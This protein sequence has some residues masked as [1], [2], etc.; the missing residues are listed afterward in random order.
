MLGKDNMFTL[1]LIGIVTN[2]QLSYSATTLRVLFIGSSYSGPAHSVPQWARGE[3]LIPGALLAAQ[4]INSRDDILQELEIEVVPIV[5]PNCSIVEGIVKTMEEILEQ[6]NKMLSVIGL[7]CNK[8]A[9]VIAALVSREPVSLIQLSGATAL[10]GGLHYPHHYSTLAGVEYHARAILDLMQALNWT[11]IGLLN[12]VSEFDNYYTTLT[13]AFVSEVGMNTSV[14]I[15]FHSEVG[16]YGEHDTTVEYA[17]RKVQLSKIHIVVAF[18][19]PYK[20]FDLIC[21]AYLQGLTWPNYA[22]ILSDVPLQ[23]LHKTNTSDCNTETLLRAMEYVIVIQQVVQPADPHGNLVSGRSYTS[24]M[25][26][27]TNHTNTFNPFANIVYDSVWGLGLASNNSLRELQNQSMHTLTALDSNT[28]NTIGAKLLTTHFTGASGTFQFSSSNNR[29]LDRTIHISQIHNQSLVTIGTLHTNSSNTIFNLSNLGNNPPTSQIAR[30]YITVHIAATVT[31]T[32]AACASLLLVIGVFLLFIFY[33]NQAEVKAASKYLSISM[34]LGCCLLLVGA[35]LHSITSHLIITRTSTK[36]STCMIEIS[37][38]SIGLDMIIA[39]ATAKTLRIAYLFTHFRSMG[40]AWSDK[41]LLGFAALLVIG[42]V[43]LLVVWFVVDPYQLEDR[44]T[45]VRGG[46]HYSVVQQCTSVHAGVWLSVVLLYTGVLCV[47]L[48]VLAYRTRRI[49]RENFKDTK[50]LNALI[51]GIIMTAI[52]CT[53]IWGI[54]RLVGLSQASKT[55]ANLGYIII[56]ILCQAFLF[57][58]KIYPPLRRHI[59]MLRP[60]YSARPNTI[61]Y[62]GILSE[63]NYH[64]LNN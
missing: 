19:P 56:P 44:K 41:G 7:S 62:G 59:E 17:I 24:Y 60:S 4:E 11:K 53:S 52:I 30:V 26:A 15:L 38:T 57:I 9:G 51:A 42:K 63:I 61:P 39:T 31:L 10:G 37:S 13:E 33:R 22:W 1:L 36:L 18:F 55:M 46:G 6:R 45:F 2:A 32:A 3:E 29:Q 49:K 43:C 8:L 25:E 21:R 28:A 48:V 23:D 20:S 14:E 16:N 58:P 34:F 50:K 47:V 5:V 40:K 35:T 54:L 64:K 12:S 27:M